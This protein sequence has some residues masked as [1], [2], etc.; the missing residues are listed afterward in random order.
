M[1]SYEEGLYREGDVVGEELVCL[2]LEADALSCVF[3]RVYRDVAVLLD[4]FHHD[5]VK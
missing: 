3:A 4:V 5:A 1:L 2:K